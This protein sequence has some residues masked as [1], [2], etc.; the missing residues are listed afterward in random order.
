MRPDPP[1]RRVLQAHRDRRL[2]PRPHRPARPINKTLRNTSKKPA[3]V[4]RGGLF[5]L[6]GGGFYGVEGA[7]GAAELSV[8]AGAVSELAGAPPV[9][10]DGAGAGEEGGG[11][12][13]GGVTTTTGGG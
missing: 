11:A 7:V 4:F 3:P 9:A 1:A 8:A 6:S 2:R 13:A 5:T 10:D 12:A